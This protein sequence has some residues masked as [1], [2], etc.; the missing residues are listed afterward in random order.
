VWRGIST[1]GF[2][3]GFL[4]LF[5]LAI[6]LLNVN[7]SP[8]ESES[9]SSSPPS[10]DINAVLRSHDQELLRLPH[11]VG[12]YVGLLPDEKTPCLKVMLSRKDTTTE[13]SLPKVLEGYRVIAEVTGDIRPLR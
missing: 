4:S 6:L 7:A 8:N 1:F 11:V 9:P 3:K 5:A 13:K 2:R 10:R 12:V